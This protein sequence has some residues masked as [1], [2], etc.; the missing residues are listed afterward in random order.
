MLQTIDKKVQNR[1]SLKNVQD[2]IIAKC[3]YR[4]RKKTEETIK[5]LA[6]FY[7]SWELGG[8]LLK[9]G[10]ALLKFSHAALCIRKGKVP[11]LKKKLYPPW[12]SSSS[13]ASNSLN[14]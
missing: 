8:M 5:T 9:L 14:E 1:S 2:S 12:S 7:T 4:C 10:G 11:Q 6:Y 13:L 3:H